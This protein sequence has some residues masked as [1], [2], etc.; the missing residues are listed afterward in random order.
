M[1]HPSRKGIYCDLC[2]DE[3][4]IN[5]TKKEITY[6]TV[7]MKSVVT[8]DRVA[9]EIKDVLDMDFCEKCHGIL[10]ERVLKVSEVNNKKREIYGK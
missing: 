10:R 7:N 9:Q 2:G 3:V 5:E 8:R 1:F 6:Y 4:L